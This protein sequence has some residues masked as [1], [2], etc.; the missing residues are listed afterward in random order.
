VTIKRL[1]KPGERIRL[2]FENTGDRVKIDLAENGKQLEAGGTY[3]ISGG[4]RSLIFSVSQNASSD[5]S[6]Y[7]GR[8][9]IP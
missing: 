3:M 7:L 9:L 8:L 2:Q 4:G 5:D 6:V 1:D